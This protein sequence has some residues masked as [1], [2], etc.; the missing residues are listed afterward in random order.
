M[1]DL[2]RLAKRLVTLG[3]V[4]VDV[5]EAELAAHAVHLVEER[6]RRRLRG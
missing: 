5:A 2:R 4:R 3:R 6:T 1:L